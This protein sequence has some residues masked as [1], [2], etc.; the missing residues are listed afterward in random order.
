MTL[1]DLS[2]DENRDGCGLIDANGK[3]V[4][5]GI[6]GT[7]S[8][9]TRRAGAFSSRVHNTNGTLDT[10]FDASGAGDS[11]SMPGVRVIGLASLS[12]A[13]GIMIDPSSGR[14]TVVGAAVGSGSLS[15]GIGIVF[16]NPD[17][18]FDTTVGN[19]TGKVITNPGTG[20]VEAGTDVVAGPSGHFCTCVGVLDQRG[21]QHFLRR[22]HIAQ[23]MVA[24]FNSD[25]TLTTSLP[26]PAARVDLY[27]ISRRQLQRQY[28]P[29]GSASRM[30]RRPAQ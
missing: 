22:A 15:G 13:S 3:A 9:A 25:G 17:G 18:S 5:C 2:K 12:G 21:R 20:I 24:E 23:F 4:V 11:H 27:D 29:G 28:R 7:L 10:S 6:T 30:T 8:G 1:L 26:A 19:G 14:I 16:L